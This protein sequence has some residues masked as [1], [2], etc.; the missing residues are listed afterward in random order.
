MTEYELTAKGIDCYKKSD[1]LV[2]STSP[3]SS[4]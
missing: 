3:E 4:E 1:F 2:M